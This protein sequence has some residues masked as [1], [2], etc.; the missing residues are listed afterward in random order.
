MNRYDFTRPVRDPAMF[1]GRRALRDEI[2]DGVRQG[3]SFAIIGGT[4]IGKT[5]LL[6]Q[7]R[8]ALLD[9]LKA[10]QSAVIGPVFLSTHELPPLSQS[11]IYRRI[12]DEFRVTMGI[13]GTDEEWQRGVRLFDQNL[14]EDRAFNA[15]RQALEVILQSREAD[16][17]I[18]IMIDEVDELRR[19]DWSHFFFNNLRH[20]IS[21]TTAGDRIAIV[22]AGTLAIRSLYEVAGSPFLNV[23]HGTKSLE[24]LSRGETEELVGRPTD[25]QIDPAV[26]STI[27][28]ETGGHPFLTQYLM[29]Q[30]CTL[31]GDK[32]ASV[33]EEHVHAIV[34]K[35]FDERTDFQN[36]VAEFTDTE[37]QAYRLIVNNTQGVTRAELVRA[38]SDPKRVDDAIRMLIHIGVVREE[39]PNSNR[40]LVGGAMF[41]RWFFER[42]GDQPTVDPKPASVSQPPPPA[43]D[44]VRLIKVFVASPGDVEEERKAVEP[45]V[46]EINQTIADRLGCV[47][48]VVKWE[49]DVYPGTSPGGAQPVI[50]SQIDVEDMDLV[51]GIF[52]RRFGT[53][54][55]LGLSG[56][57]HE[58]QRAVEA[59]IRHRGKPH[60][61]IYFSDRPVR[62]ASVAEAEQQRKVL[63]LRDR[64]KDRVLTF[65]YEQVQQF[66]DLVRQHLASFLQDYVDASGSRGQATGRSV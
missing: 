37:R 32:L 63:E 21:Q 14:P 2:L 51:I 1:F 66:K 49:T 34:E 26:V 61:M 56:S 41:R 35:Y 7:V 44:M 48:K 5:S 28:Q 64:L 16:R 9:Q 30:L 47:L 59:S 19:Y 10:P 62:I 23:I 39:R 20:L 54:T 13:P 53:D 8:Q 58:I 36:W 40:Y 22:I 52:W 12:I 27:F 24:L 4:R 65:P 29:K 3:A 31:L 15:F 60:V 55:G 50:D 18:V 42:F 45:V 43:K 6:F 25:H 17:R 33:T 38:L 11:I 46:A 57:A